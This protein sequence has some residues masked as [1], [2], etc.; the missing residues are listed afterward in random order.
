MR[1]ELVSSLILGCPFTWPKSGA[2]MCTTQMFVDNLWINPL[3]QK[4]AFE[5]RLVQLSRPLKSAKCGLTA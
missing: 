3:A 5:G 2:I 4:P 1:G